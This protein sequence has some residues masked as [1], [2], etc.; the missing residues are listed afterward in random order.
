MKIK[1]LIFGRVLFRRLRIGLLASGIV[2]LLIVVTG[3]APA[4]AALNVTGDGMTVTFVSAHMVNKLAVDVDFSVSCTPQ[5]LPPGDSNFYISTF[6]L[7]QTNK[8]AI[9]SYVGEI[10]GTPAG[11]FPPIVCNGT[12]QVFTATVLPQNCE[13]GVIPLQGCTFGTIPYRPGTAFISNLQAGVFE[14][15]GT[16]CGNFVPCEE[17]FNGSGGVKITG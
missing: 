5:T 7:T 11:A 3:T 2:A 13:P 12:P 1:R 17:V 4:G 15:S 14:T 9:A 8:D 10:N 16:V 6:T